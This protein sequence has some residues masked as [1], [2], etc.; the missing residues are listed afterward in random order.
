MNF[1]LKNDLGVKA[2]IC[3][4]ELIQKAAFG[5]LTL[6][7]AYRSFAAQSCGLRSI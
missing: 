5:S 7:D 2:I 1:N 6:F 4:G 3:E